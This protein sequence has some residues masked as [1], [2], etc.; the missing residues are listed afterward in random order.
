MLTTRSA[1]ELAS[2]STDILAPTVRARCPRSRERD[3]RPGE[4]AR[5]P[6]GAI[7][8]AST[9]AS[10]AGVVHA[11]LL[12]GG[13]PGEAVRDPPGPTPSPHAAPGQHQRPTGTV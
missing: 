1:T 3:T 5:D 6:P 13:V 12:P 2:N 4:A 9:V 10:R 8:L 11:G 7:L